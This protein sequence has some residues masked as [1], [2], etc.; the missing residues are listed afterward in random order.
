[1]R[2]ERE[3]AKEELKALEDQD[4]EKSTM[5]VEQTEGSIDIGDVVG[6]L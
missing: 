4:P 2:Q 6:K 5:Q 1:M 3:A